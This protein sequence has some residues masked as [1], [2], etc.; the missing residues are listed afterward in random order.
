MGQQAIYATRRDVEHIFGLHAVTP[1][2]LKDGFDTKNKIPAWQEM[3]HNKFTNASVVLTLLG[4]DRV[5]A[6]DASD[7]ENPDFIIDLNDEISKNYY[8]K[9][10]VIIDMGTMEHVFD[11]PTALGNIV[12]MLKKSGDV[13]LASPSSNSIDHGFYSFSPTLFFDFFSLTDFLISAVI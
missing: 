5:F 1:K 7:Y 6:A 2:V 8:E 9:F 3:P 12:K 13:I 11:I 4:A 10:D